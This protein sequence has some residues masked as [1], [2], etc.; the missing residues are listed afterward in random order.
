MLLFKGVDYRTDFWYRSKED[1]IN[2]IK[3]SN[4]NEKTGLL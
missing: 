3:N 1:A 2:L 4:L